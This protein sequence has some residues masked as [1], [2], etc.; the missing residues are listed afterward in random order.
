MEVVSSAGIDKDLV[1]WLGR[2]SS[3]WG[4]IGSPAVVPSS[5]G[6][7]VDGEGILLSGLGIT[8][9]GCN[10]PRSNN[11]SG[12]DSGRVLRE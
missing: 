9:D 6:E 8:V 12:S 11:S 1:G 4:W 2:Q 5:I 3:P 7:L 10:S